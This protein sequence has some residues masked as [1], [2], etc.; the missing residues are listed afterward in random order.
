MIQ[1]EITGIDEEIQGL[2]ILARGLQEMLALV[3]SRTEAV[4]IAETYT[5]LAQRLA[6]TIE[7]E[8]R[9]QQNREADQDIIA[10]IQHMMQTLAQENEEPLA[11]DPVAEMQPEY[12]LDIASRRLVEEI[13]GVRLALRTIL[14]LAG[15]AEQHSETGEYLCMTQAYA[16]GCSRLVKLLLV[17]RQAQ[18]HLD[19]HL[20]RQVQQAI[21]S[22]V[23]EWRPAAPRDR[24]AD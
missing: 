18:G 9:L 20:R 19:E 21:R 4:H 17:E 11:Q 13:A 2:R 14:R 6:K 10:R 3:R 23:H 7:A 24:Q 15:E 12:M 1:D 16:I 22:V 5:L 8:K